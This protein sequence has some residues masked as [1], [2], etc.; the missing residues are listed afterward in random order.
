[1]RRIGVEERRARLGLRHHLAAAAR[2]GV[3]EA[4]RDLVGLH[5]TDPASVYLA[6]RARM[7]VPEVAAVDRALYEDRELVRIL[8]HTCA[9]RVSHHSIKKLWHQ[10]PPAAPRQLPLLY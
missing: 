8:F 9:R 3:V 7:A 4:A 2:A 5:G 1:M 10:L 6:A